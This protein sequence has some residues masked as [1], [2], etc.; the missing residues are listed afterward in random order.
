MAVPSAYYVWCTEH[1]VKV[2]EI[3]FE[4][5]RILLIK[6]QKCGKLTRSS[7][8]GNTHESVILPVRPD[9]DEGCQDG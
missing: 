7:L 3:T 8:H 1:P 9:S 4:A 6:C 5:T 2:D